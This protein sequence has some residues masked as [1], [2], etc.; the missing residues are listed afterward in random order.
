M[1]KKAETV[2]SQES[3]TGAHYFLPSGTIPLARN[4]NNVSAHNNSP[5]RYKIPLSLRQRLYARLR[6]NTFTQFQETSDQA[7]LV[8]G[9]PLYPI[10][11]EWQAIIEYLYRK[12]VLRLPHVTFDNIFPDEPKIYALRLW[13]SPSPSDGGRVISNGGYSRGVS[14]NFEEALSKVIG[15][16]LERYPQTLYRDGELYRA[17]ISDLR[18]KKAH[19]LD[20]LLVDKFSE[21]QKKRFPSRNFDTKSFFRFVKGQSLTRGAEAFIPA[22]MVFM[23]YRFA[24]NE[25]MLLYPNSNGAGGMFSYEE[26]VLSGLYELVQRDAFLVHW[27]TDTPPRLV[28][29]DSISNADVRACID[30]LQRYRLDFKILDTTSDVGIPSFAVV[31]IDHSGVGPA[32]SLGGGCG[33]DPGKAILRAMTEA[34]GVR[35]WLRL[36]RRG[37]KYGPLPKLLDREPF[38]EDWGPLRRL[39]L[40]YGADSIPFIEPFLSGE[41]AP[42]D[43]SKSRS[44]VSARE[45]LAYALGAFASRG[46]G[47]EVFAY[48]AEHEIL[49]SLGYSSVKVCVP[50]LLPLYMMETYAPLEAK[51]LKLG[52]R[53]TVPH[54]FP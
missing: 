10:P 30:D 39:L 49:S 47:Y 35:S 42:V 43:L 40:W 52:V 1:N 7:Q 28:A 31:I 53:N 51:R 32:V 36:A 45:E 5:G 8:L 50:E 16:L 2:Q 15:E 26:A 37:Q 27:L 41:V 23:N 4:A 3:A 19:F 44:F 34:I 46:E 14:Y 54:P 24:E 21:S 38:T 33:F 6:R 20:P 9:N 12:G 25:P 11:S 29:P 17:S 13:A 48:R 22:Q 18:K